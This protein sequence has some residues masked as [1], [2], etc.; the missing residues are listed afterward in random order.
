MSS[1]KID[2]E[3]DFSIA[4]VLMQIELIHCLRSHV[5]GTDSEVFLPVKLA[6]KVVIHEV[7]SNVFRI[8]ASRT[9]C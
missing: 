2:L 7:E 4:D 6:A 1:T 5:L 8:E 3:E 9:D